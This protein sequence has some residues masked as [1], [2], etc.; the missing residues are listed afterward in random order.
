MPP[1]PG[2]PVVRYLEL[3]LAL[4][5]HVDGLVDAY[6]GPPALA[7]RA[8]AGAPRAPRAI[9]HDLRLLL[10]DLEFDPDLEPDRRHWLLAQ[11]R[12]LRVT[13][14]RLAGEAIGYAD[15]VEACYG[16]RPT[17]V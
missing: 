3:G 2:D 5:R 12:G 10:A 6:F 13:A 4:G 8:A 1:E 11:V 14:A 15:E 7:G 17:K 16:V 9:E